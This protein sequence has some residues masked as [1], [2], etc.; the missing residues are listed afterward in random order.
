MSWQLVASEPTEV[1]FGDTHLHTSLS[2]DSFLKQNQS[3]GPDT[4]Y[5]WAKGLPVIHPY[6]RARVQIDTPLDFLVVSDHAESMGVFNAVHHDYFE[7]P[8]AGLFRRVKTWFVTIVVK[9]MMRDEE[10]SSQFYLDVMAKTPE[11]NDPDPVKNQVTRA[12][13]RSPLGDTSMVVRSAW[14]DIVEAADRH[15][16]PGK[17]TSLIGWEWSSTPT[18]INLHRVV[19]TPDDASKAK[20]FLPY[21]SD[22]SEYPEDLWS[23]LETTQNKT[24]A[25]FV[26]IPHN[27]NVSK[28]YMFGET[29]LD[30]KPITAD[31]ARTRMQWE[32]VT[33]VSQVKG[34]SESHQD[35][36]PEDAFADFENYEFYLQAYSQEYEAKEGD[37]ARSALKRGLEFEQKI[38]VNPYKFGMIGSTDSH[39]SLSS[40]E[41]GN[42]WG[43]MANDSIP[44]K[45]HKGSFIDKD[46]PTG[47]DMAAAGLAAVWAKENTREEIYAAFQRKEV[48]ATTGPR[49][50]VRLF[51][52][53]DFSGF[54]QLSDDLTEIGYAKGVPMGGDLTWPAGAVSDV[55]G[56]NK[57]V[58]QLLIRATKDP[59]NANLDRIQVIKGW[60]DTSG[61]KLER[62]YNVAWAGDRALD[63]QGALQAV[64]NTVDLKT[65]TY[66][67]SIGAEEL[68]VLWA[69]PDFNAEQHAFYYVRVLQIPTPRHSL[70]DALSLQ[71]KLPDNIPSIIQERA[72]TS[73][74]WYTP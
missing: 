74:V 31:Y 10:S 22:Q 43:K 7:E 67:N 23:W 50:R 48:Y 1:Y 66:D 18:G 16:E 30:G 42:F 73:P 57:K 33:E 53:W 63:S 52:G 2:F 21:G 20:H 70:Y 34:D 27:P 46:G 68:S 39:T 25:R 61:R 9:Y 29:T 12:S 40:A 60:V 49:L 44:E 37:Y 65:A 8:E 71:Q 32:P 13:E 6:N 24:G 36:S 59:K 5:R 54:D 14:M 11:G 56:E 58:P 62:I 47:W 69:D 51:A 19:F 38:G 72:Y 3:A 17:F 4:A 35:L 41:E 28:G 55:G 15:Y 26:A 45:K 64:G